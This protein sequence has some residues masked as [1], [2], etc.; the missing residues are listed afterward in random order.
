MDAVKNNDSFD[1]VFDGVVYKTV[2]ARA[3]WNKIMR[4]TWDHAE[5]G[6]LFVDRINKKNNLWYCEEISCTNPCGQH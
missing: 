2:Q 5:P 3:L 1:L 4:N 6:V